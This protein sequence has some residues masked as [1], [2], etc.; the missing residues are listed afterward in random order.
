MDTNTEEQKLPN[1][2]IVANSKNDIILR[3]ITET[4]TFEEL[5]TILGQQPEH[6]V[7]TE[8]VEKVNNNLG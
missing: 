2:Q 1:S 5:S 6:I 8:T 3:A 7:K 4:K